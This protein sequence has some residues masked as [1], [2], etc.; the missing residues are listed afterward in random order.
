MENRTAGVGTGVTSP[1]VVTVPIAA[2]E[3]PLSKDQASWAPACWPPAT[4]AAPTPLEVMTSTL[5]HPS[6][7][8][9]AGAPEAQGSA[10]RSIEG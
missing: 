8:S 7:A 5:N 1:P 6:G 2:A 10:V 4:P 9:A 3:A